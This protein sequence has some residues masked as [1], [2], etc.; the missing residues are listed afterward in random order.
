MNTTETAPP[1]S[2]H[3]VVMPT[4]WKQEFESAK[5]AYE[6]EYKKCWDLCEAAKKY[7]ANDG[8]QGRYSGVKL[9]IAREELL[10]AI[11]AGMSA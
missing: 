6:R 1:G 5:S 11:E 4:D 3:P 8:S 2:L 10:A 7:L 9:A